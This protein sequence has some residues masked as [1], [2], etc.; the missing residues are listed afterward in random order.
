MLADAYFTAGRGHLVAQ[1]YA[2]ASPADADT[3]W[4]VL[5]DGC[6]ASPHTDVGARLLAHVVAG[7]LSVGAPDLPAAARKAR[8]LADALGLPHSSLDATCLCLRLAHDVIEARVWGDGVVAWAD[9]DGTRRV[10]VVDYPGGAPAYLSYGLDPRRGE[11]WRDG[12]HDR[13]VIRCRIGAAPWQDLGRGR[14]TA[15]PLRLPR[16]SVR[17]VAIG[18][19]GLTAVQHRVPGQPSRPVPVDEVLAELTRFATSAGR[20]L[21][22]R[23]RRVC[24]R[25]AHRRGWTLGDDLSVAALVAAPEVP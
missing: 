17:W 18:S 14:G 7:Q 9:G 4:V 19:D 2:L 21:A 3:P 20:P 8:Q 12:E 11:A 25:L 22:R 6:S 13:Y 16:S 1:D 15:P 5:C 10:Q 23:A 24:G